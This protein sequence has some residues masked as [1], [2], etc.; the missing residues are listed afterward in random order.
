MLH[1]EEQGKKKTDKEEIDSL[2]E[3]DFRV[4]VNK[5]DLEYWELKGENA[6]NVWQGH[7]KIKEQTNSGE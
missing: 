2:S 4:M 1:T 6:R 5:C 3:K 7:H